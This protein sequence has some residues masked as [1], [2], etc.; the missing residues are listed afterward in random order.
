MLIGQL[1]VDMSV[2]ICSFEFK[3]V[4]FGVI[5]KLTK[6]GIMW[7]LDLNY[8]YL[9][10]KVIVTWVIELIKKSIVAIEEVSTYAWTIT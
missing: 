6:W 10:L 9:Q 2:V 7:Y 3:S 1:K 8:T 5:V 4:M